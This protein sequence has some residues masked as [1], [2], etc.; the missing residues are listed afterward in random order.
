[1]L[2]VCKPILTQVV[3]V[4]V[5]FGV[6]VDDVGVKDKQHLLYL[7]H[8]KRLCTQLTSSSSKVL[9]VFPSEIHHP[10]P[11]ALT[12]DLV[13]LFEE[14]SGAMFRGINAIVTNYFNDDRF[15]NR[16]LKLSTNGVNLLRHVQHLPFHIGSWRPDV[17]FPDCSSKCCNSQVG[18]GGGEFQ[19][20]EINARYSC[21]A[22][23]ISFEQGRAMFEGKSNAKSCNY[24]RGCPV[25][26]VKGVGNIP[27]LFESHFYKENSPNVIGVVKKHSQP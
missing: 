20:C 8:H 21:N 2:K 11:L 7:K 16:Y 18:G 12:T 14:V 15:Y 13:D 5:D 9:E 23:Y 22:Y 17:L 26:P 1:M 6:D 4:D 19:I 27:N 3:P 10:Y 25:T 24:L